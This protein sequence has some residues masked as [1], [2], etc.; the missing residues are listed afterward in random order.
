MKFL[1]AFAVFTSVLLLAFLIAV[2]LTYLITTVYSPSLTDVVMTAQEEGWAHRPHSAAHIWSE[3]ENR[4]HSGAY[5][6]ASPD[7]LF[8]TL[9]FFLFLLLFLS[10]ALYRL[11]L[12]RRK[13]VGCYLN[14]AS[15]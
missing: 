3:Y 8:Q 14:G 1:S 10:L 9:F 2:V 5:L 6:E 7:E 4:L 12:K 13:R 15:A 11:I